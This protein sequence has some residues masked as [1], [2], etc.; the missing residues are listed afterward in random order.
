MFRQEA[1]D[2]QHAGGLGEIVLIRPVSFTF[3]TLLAAAMALLVVGF[4]LFGSYTKRSTV[5]GQLVPASGQVKVHAPQAGIVLR[6]FVQEGQAVRRGERLMVLSSERYGS[7]AGP[8]QAGISR[9]LEQ[10]RDSLTSKVASLQRE[11]TTL[12]AQTDSQQRLL[13]LASDA[14]ARYQGLM[15]KGYISMDQL[16]QRQAELLGQR[17]TLQGLERERTSLRQQLTERRNELAGLS[18]RQANQLAETRRQLSAVE[19]DLAE[20]EAKRTLL[21]TAP[22]SGIATA[23]LA[24]AG[25]TVDSSRPLLSI[26]PADTPLQAELYAP[27]KSIGFIR[28]GDAVLIRYQAYPYQKFGQYHGKVQS[29]SRASVSYAELSSMVG[30][31]PGLGQDGEQLYRLRVTLDDQAVTAYGQPRPLQSGMLLDADILQDTRRLYEWV[32]EPLYSLTGKL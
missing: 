24:E 12:A 32:L 15:D 31:V 8:V 17:Q 1:L 7:D 23:V 30:G 26:V 22:E 10:R 20:S 19:Q 14:A 21:V 3:L 4:F 9:R 5:S 18:A 27:S 28:P 25:Q 2:A 29:I 13:A 6:K 16:Q 11:L